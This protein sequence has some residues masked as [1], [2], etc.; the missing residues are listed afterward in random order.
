MKDFAYRLQLL[1]DQKKIKQ[2]D[3]A[4][5]VGINRSRVSLWLNRKVTDPQRTTLQKLSDFFGCNIE[6][7][8]SGT[9]AIYPT[10]DPTGQG[11][12]LTGNGNIQ[13]GGRV[14]GTITGG[15]QAGGIQLDSDE[16]ELI[17]LLREFGGKKM[18]R[19]FT[20]ELLEIQKLIDG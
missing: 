1:M 14:S 18:I 12:T 11:Q 16:Q 9:G 7:L 4:S 13:A 3:L 20:K 17:F 6:W 5:G 2:S 15:G 10:T 19:K 8:A